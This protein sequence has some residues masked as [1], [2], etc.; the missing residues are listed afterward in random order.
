LFPVEERFMGHITIARV[1]K[2]FAKNELLNYIDNYTLQPHD[3]SL[4]EFKLK[5]SILLSNGPIYKTIK[6][7]KKTDLSTCC[8]CGVCDFKQTFY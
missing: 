1:K 2:I 5:Q 3:I 7:F 4:S 6:N 8:L